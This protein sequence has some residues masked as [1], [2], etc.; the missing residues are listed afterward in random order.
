LNRIQAATRWS[1]VSNLVSVPTDCPQRE[2]NAWT[3]DAH[4]AA[5]QALF[6]FKPAAVYTKWLHDLV[7]SQREKG[8][9]PGISPTSGWGYDRLNGPAWDSA[10]L[11]IPA[12][13]HLYYGDERILTRHYDAFKRYVDYVS[14]R[15]PSGIAN[16]GLNDWLPYR[17][18]TPA[19]ITSTAY[20]YRDARIVAQTAALLG[21]HDEAEQYRQLAQRIFAAFNKRFFDREK[22][23]YGN[24]S[25]TSLSCALHQGLVAAEHREAVT[26][27]LVKAIEQRDDHLDT[28]VLGAKYVLLALLENS[29]TDVAYQIVNQRTL[30]G[31]GHWIEQGATTLWEDWK[32]TG[33][34]NHILLGDVSAWFYKAL[35]G[36]NPDP[37]A[38]GWENVIIR[39][40]APRGLTSARARY[41][42]IRGPIASAWQIDA[43]GFTLAVEIPANSSATIFLPTGDAAS[44]EEGGQPVAAAS[45][46]RFVESAGGYAQYRVGSGRYRFRA[47]PRAP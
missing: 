17:T 26:R 18:K 7:D 43:A 25:Q 37:A 14:R 42:S 44:V 33:S 30:P 38:P 32:G 34:L 23:S 8:D 39:P 41:D 21:K 22:H 6:N 27:S 12:Y 9:L 1:Y 20:Y 16:F 5:E 35:A 2:K 28:G 15:A 24:G 46:V 36:I 40:F 31:W 11:L 29:R 13:M 45:H 3:G 47:A 4:L 10:L 19:G